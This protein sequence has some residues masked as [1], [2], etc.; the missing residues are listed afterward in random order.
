MAKHKETHETHHKKEKKSTTKWIVLFVVVLAILFFLKARLAAP[1]VEDFT[2]VELPEPEPEAAPEPEPEPEPEVV[3]VPKEAG[4]A[5]LEKEELGDDD[6][7]A[8]VTAE[9]ELF[10]NLE[11]EIEEE[12]GIRYISLRIYNTL[13]EDLTISPVGVAKG[14]NTFFMVNGLVDMDPGCDSEVAEPGEYVTCSKLGQDSERFGN[15][16]ESKGINRISVQAPIKT[17][18]LLV[19]CADE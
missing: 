2:P 19:T 7:A 13:D 16:G 14:Y 1:P 17:E 5:I 4:R 15:V 8:D 9:P 18:A 10:S 3:E 12:T 6:L 11:C